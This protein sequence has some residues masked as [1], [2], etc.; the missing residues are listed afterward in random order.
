MSLVVYDIE[1]FKGC[2][3]YCDIDVKTGEIKK[4][5]IHKDR[6][7]SCELYDHLKELKGMIGFNVISFDYPIIHLFMNWFPQAIK[8]CKKS[9]L[10]DETP[11]E[12]VLMLYNK[13]QEIIGQQSN[14][15]MNFPSIREKDMLIPQMDLFKMYHFDNPARKTS[16]KSLQISM[17]YPNVL[18][19]PIHHSKED[20]TL[21]EVETI[22][23][24]NINDVLST[25]EFYKKSKGKID[26]RIGLQKKYGISCINYSDS[27]IGEELT[28]KLYCD[29]TGLDYWT[30]KKL[31]TH[32]DE[33]KLSDCILD[34]IQFK[35]KPFQD[36]LNKLKTKTVKET[37][38][39][40]NES[41]I[42]KG[43]KYLYGLGGLHACNKA[44]VYTNSNTHVIIDLDVSSLYPSIAINNQFYIEH[45]GKDFIDVYENGIVK[46]RL[47]A[48]RN[49]DVII[50]EGFKLSANSVF[51][52]SN[53]EHSFLF[54]SEYTLKTTLN[55]QLL[56]SML[57]VDLLELPDIKILQVNTD[58]ISVLINDNLLNIF[59]KICEEWCKLTKFQ[60]EFVEY[61][62]MVIRDVN[63]YAAI[64]TKSKLKYKGFFEIEKE[65]HKD[66][67][68]K[69]VPIALSNYFFNNIPVEETI[70]E[71]KNIYDFC[72]KQKFNSDSY[73][74]TSELRYDNNNNPFQYIEKQQKNVRYY[75]SNKGKSF[76]KKYTKGT[77]EVIN[78]GYEVT[79]FNKYEEKDMKDYDINY[80]FYIY[81]CHKEILSIENRQLNLF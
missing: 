75:I 23:E 15:F 2:F 46:P 43:V 70:R 10:Y 24:Y 80:N 18:D 32:R 78:K 26:L 37:K 21:K 73:G 28:L 57:L 16:L 17:N 54:D 71:W 3:S 41:V 66:N 30:V 72:G 63:N 48:K 39:S 5:V 67:S 9:L 61:K 12:I 49:G 31:R 11:E 65:Y 7:D 69:I 35:I 81:S 62:K 38:G 56:L 40:I 74:Q 36:L 77:S 14:S 47:E 20:I 4:F 42:Y 79:I 59:Y 50:S 13:A 52:K 25:Y 22:L 76:V 33:I 1:T 58:G 53:D 55:G 51:G 29:K 34:Y 6:D 45:L 68:F 60:L 44:G 19:S 27:K 8:N 64:S